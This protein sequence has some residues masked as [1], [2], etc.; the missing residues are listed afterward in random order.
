MYQSAVLEERVFKD[1][2]G[3]NIMDFDPMYLCTYLFISSLQF[4]LKI[5][6]VRTIL[7]NIFFT[8]FFA[9]PGNPAIQ[10]RK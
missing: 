2:S 8:V 5:S 7:Y 9:N 4:Y 1:S 6:V 3:C 10:R